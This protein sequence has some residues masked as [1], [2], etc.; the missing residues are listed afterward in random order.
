M[1]LVRLELDLDREKGWLPVILLLPEIIEAL[2]AVP[3]LLFL[4]LSP[5]TILLIVLNVSLK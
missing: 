5:C 1:S 4:L 2:E 3:K